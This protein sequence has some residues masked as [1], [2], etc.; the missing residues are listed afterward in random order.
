[1]ALVAKGKLTNR[2]KI[3]IDKYLQCWNAAQAARDAGYKNPAQNGWENKQ[4]E[5][6]QA[7]IQKRLSDIHMSADEALAILAEHARGDLGEFVD[8]DGSIDLSM[9]RAKGLTHLIKS[10]TKRTTPQGT[11][12]KVE[13]YSAQDA[14]EKVLRVSGKIKPET[15]ELVI[16]YADPNDKPAKTS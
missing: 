3:W 7:E 16:R 9:A 15:Y 2:Q 11:L 12:Q 10:V 5:L 6:I 14:I 13:L 8:D 4:N 1:M